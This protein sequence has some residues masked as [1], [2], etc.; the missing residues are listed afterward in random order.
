MKLK[1]NSRILIT[2]HLQLL[3]DMLMNKYVSFFKKLQ[4]LILF[5]CLLNAKG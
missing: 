5:F 2:T 4:I 3:Q 1:K